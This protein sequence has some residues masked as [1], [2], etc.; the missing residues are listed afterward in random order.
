MFLL[1]D[2]CNN[3]LYNLVQLKNLGK[4]LATPKNKEIFF[5]EHKNWNISAQKQL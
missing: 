1:L 4:L 5:T 2:F 3:V